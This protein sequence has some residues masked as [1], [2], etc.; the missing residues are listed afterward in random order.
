MLAGLRHD[1]VISGH[2]QQQQVDA[3]GAG[4]HV[5]HE[6]LMAGHVDK[7]AEL[8]VTQIGIQVTQIDGDAALTLRRALISGNTGERLQQSGFAVVDMPARA[9]DHGRAPTPAEIAAC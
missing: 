1:T 2:H 7:T 9:D 6:T 8:A 3:A 4:E 5:V